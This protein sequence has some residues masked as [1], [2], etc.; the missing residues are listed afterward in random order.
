[1]TTRPYNYPRLATIKSN[2]FGWTLHRLPVVT[3]E[4]YRWALL[5]AQL[6][7]E[8]E[9]IIAPQHQ[10]F[11]L[12]DTYLIKSYCRSQTHGGICTHRYSSAA[13]IH[14]VSHSVVRRHKLR[15]VSQAGCKCSHTAA[16]C[17]DPLF[18]GIKLPG[19]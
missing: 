11:C 18:L 16:V 3:E 14:L 5:T 9:H 10:R 19:L 13:Y 12:C 8:T 4:K 15:S 7:N 2:R 1:M 17:V 6:S